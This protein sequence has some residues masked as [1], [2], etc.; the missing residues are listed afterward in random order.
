M[1]SRI[2]V[3]FYLS[4]K[5]AILFFICLFV[6][7]TEVFACVCPISPDVT[8]EDLVKYS[9]KNSS[10]VFTGKVIGFEYRKGIPNEFME[11]KKVEY[12]T[13]IVKFQVEQWWKGELTQEIFLVTDETINADGTASTS[14]CNYNFNEGESYLV[15]AYGKEKELRVSPCARTQIL[16]KAERDLEILGE[17]KKPIEKK[18]EPSK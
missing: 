16:S 7:A 5:I 10:A 1:I 15:Y 8:L 3:M 17:G 14:S 18:D 6:S 2:G 9:V 4:K 13:K 11:S 12:K